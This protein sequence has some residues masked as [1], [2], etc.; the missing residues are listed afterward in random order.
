MKILFALSSPEYLRHYDETIRVLAGNGHTIAIVA[1][2]VRDGKPVRLDAGEAMGAGVSVAGL[3]PARTDQ[4]AP[5]GRAVRGTMDFIRYLHPEFA[6]AVVLRARAKRQ[7]LPWALQ[8]LDRIRA[9]GP[10]MVARLMNGMARIERCIPPAPVLLD[11]LDAQ[12]PDLLLVTP[13]IELASD[14]VDLVRTAQARGI[15]VATLVASWDNLTNKGDLRVV[16]DLVVVWNEAQKREAIEYHRVPPSRIVVTG[17]QTFDRWFGRAPSRPREAYCQEAGLPDARPFVLFTG[18]SIF[19]A[20]ADAEMRFVRRW[21]EA[22]RS[23]G[24]PEVRDLAIVV[25]PHP[26]NGRAWN[27]DAFAGMPGVT[28]W[29]RGGYDPVDAAN[30]DGL[31]DSLYHCEAVVG[32][33]TSAMIEAAV[34]GRP[35]LSV[36]AEEFAGSQNGSRHF[37]HLLPENG[38]FLRVAHTLDEHIRQLAEVLRHPDRVG[39]E[40]SQFVASFVRPQ[41]IERT[42]TSVLVEAIEEF[43]ASAAPRPATRSLL[44]VIG[45]ALLYPIGWWPSFIA[46]PADRKRLVRRPSAPALPSR[47]TDGQLGAVTRAALLAPSLAATILLLFFTI[48]ELSGQS[49]LSYQ[50]PA[51]IAEAA[52]MAM[53]SEVLR[54]LRQGQDPMTVYDVRPDI[55]SSSVT[56]ATGLEAAIWSRRVRLLGILEREGAIPNHEVRR[57]LVCL[58]EDIRAHELAERLVQEGNF[59]CETGQAYGLI[60]ARSQ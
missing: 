24:E 44:G 22:L 26:Y 23:S 28:V 35:V 39:R 60:A 58:A 51:N 54:F 38:G 9:L 37:R 36:A 41:G 7:A 49:P 59:D 40:L 55:I 31:F 13:L 15:R 57:H 16:T 52:G 29:P 32:I 48:S 46:A 18:S 17:A 19:I 11:F 5:V 27:P 20:R 47:S 42:S 10:R 2:T 56:R 50:A 3:V 1:G 45:G 34:V 25:R 6:D 8:G 21:I 30:R 12:S 14:Q 33:N 53:E 4:W 43:G